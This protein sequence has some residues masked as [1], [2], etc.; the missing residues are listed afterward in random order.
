M[1]QTLGA[2]TD[3]LSIMMK[4]GGGK[5]GVKPLNTPGK[6]SSTKG[7]SLKKSNKTCFFTKLGQPNNARGQGIITD[8]FKSENHKLNPAMGPSE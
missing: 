3:I 2:P 8:Y 5:G 6:V 7:I 4:Q 1:I